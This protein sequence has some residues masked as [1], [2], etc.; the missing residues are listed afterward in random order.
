MPSVTSPKVARGALS[1]DF[2]PKNATMRLVVRAHCSALI[3][4]LLIGT[5]GPVQAQI[6]L[7]TKIPFRSM[8]GF[9]NNRANPLWGCGGSVFVRMTPPAYADGV[10]APAGQGLPSPRVISNAIC[11][12]P[13]S[14][15]NREGYT[16][17]LWQWGQFI[18]HDMTM[19]FSAEPLEPFPVAVPVGDPYFDPSGSGTQVIDLDRSEFAMLDGVRQQMNSNTS[20][21][22][23]SA[24]YGSDSARAKELRTLDGTGRL[25]TSPG[26]L[27]PYNVHGFRNFPVDDDPAYFL[28]GDV[29]AN[30]QV[31]L[32][33][34]QTVFMREHNY[35]AGVVHH[36]MRHLD[37]EAVYQ[38]ARAIVGAEIQ[39]VTYRE[40]LP[41]LL[42]PNALRP[43]DGYH[44]DVNATIETEFSTAAYRMGHTLLSPQLL[45]LDEGLDPIPQGSLPLKDAFFSPAEFVSGGGPDPLLRGLATQRAQEFDPYVVDGV[46]NFLFGPPG[47]GGFDL[48]SLNLQRGRD[49]GIPRYNDVREAFGMPRATTFADI[50][51]DPQ[52]QALFASVYASVDDVDLWVGIISEDHCPGAVVG[53]LAHRILEDQFG[54]LRDGDRFWYQNVLPPALVQYVERQTLAKIIRRNTSI[55]RE[56][57]DDV[58]RVRSMPRFAVV[59]SVAGTSDR[60]AVGRPFPNPTRGVVNL[61][62]ALP[63]P[64]TRAVEAAVFDVQGRRVKTL[65]RETVVGGPHW[66]SWDRTDD[67]GQLVAHG[68]YFIRLRSGTF[69][70]TEKVLVIE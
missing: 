9:G 15:P 5:A 47:A 39:A 24:V 1:T 10:S 17:F 66:I 52:V 60:F 4:A 59:P 19:T 34:I 64:E 29:R 69:T 51:S 70:S 65:L 6:P 14:V 3:G 67:G 20:F 49:H 28:A 63:V 45:R 50:S 33:A 68:I 11:A 43:Y 25:K 7:S 35:V 44:P 21:I 55:G 37:E 31:G 56:L 40:F 46:R 2:V 54:R 22:D 58:F 27:L 36:L 38:M 61:A 13:H 32:T 16:D 62:F 53:E 41:V 8:D 18:D 30:E 48:A 23:G 26:N 12:Q 42:G 57:P